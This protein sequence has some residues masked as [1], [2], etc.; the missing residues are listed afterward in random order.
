MDYNATTPIREEVLDVMAKVARECYGNPSSA[1]VLGRISK[2]C[3]EDA[4]RKVAA[5]IGANPEEICFTAGGSDSDNLAI[6]GLAAGRTDGH[7]IS[8]CI[9][10]SAVRKSCDYLRGE[11]FDVTCLPVSRS[12]IVDPQ[13]I[14]DAI[15]EDTFLVTVMWANNEAGQIQPVRE[16]ARITR[17]R[18]VAFHTD[19]V[20]AFGKIPV[21]VRDVPVDL[22]SISG[23]KFYGPKGIGALYVCNGLELKPLI[24]G[25]GQEMG[26]R[27]GTE[28]VVGIA[29]LGEACRL[30]VLDLDLDPER[31]ARL[32]DMMERRILETI[33][34]TK[35]SGGTRHR[36]PNTSNIA[37]SHVEAARLVQRLDEVGIA[38]S[39]ASACKSAKSAPSNVLMKGMG[40]TREEA[41][42]AIRFSLGKH[43]TEAHVSQ[44]LEVLPGIV[45][46]LRAASSRRQQA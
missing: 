22:L 27:S 45:G 19:A 11:G 6:K 44:L 23:H 29:A 25:G 20:Q 34:E 38:V 31:I 40:L 13:S 33:P 39:G 15:R 8:T 1:H 14:A 32:R 18:G 2:A 28:D 10:H 30:A 41:M 46:D 42:G 35:V 26:L 43:T 37:F 21:S 36:V 3:I 16:I 17:E 5:S 7:V 24:H 9:E 4:R 12:G